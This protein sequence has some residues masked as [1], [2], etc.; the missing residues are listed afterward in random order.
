MGKKKRKRKRS[1][2]CSSS[3]GSSSSSNSSTYILLNCEEVVE[4]GTKNDMEA[5]QKSF[6]QCGVDSHVLR[7]VKQEAY[8]EQLSL[9]KDATI[10]KERKRVILRKKQDEALKNA[11]IADSRKEQNQIQLRPALEELRKRRIKYYT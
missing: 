4:E 10:Q 9:Q 11:T 8:V 2:G 5:L 3:S 7:V 1:N 6:I